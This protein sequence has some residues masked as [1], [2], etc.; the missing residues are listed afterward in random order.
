MHAVRRA[1]LITLLGVACGPVAPEPNATLDW[2]APVAPTPAPA[3]PLPK[4]RVEGTD[5]TDGAR[6]VRLRGVNVCSLEFDSTGANWKLDAAG[7]ALLRTLADPT[8]WKANVVRMP[9]NQ[10]WFLEDDAYV[11]RIE[12]IIDDANRLGLYVL[13]EVQW[14]LGKTLEP[15]HRNILQLPTFGEG[16]TTEAFWLRATSR[17]ANRTNLLYDLINEPHGFSDLDTARAMQA[18]VSA[19]R[20]RDEQTVI[21]V[22]G[23]NW[24]HSVDYYRTHPLEGANLVYSAHQYLPHDPP[25]H[26]EGAFVN[27]ARSLPVLI[28]EFLAEADDAAYAS[29]LVEVAEANALEGWLPWAIGCGFDED[30]DRGGEPLASLARRM[31][32]LN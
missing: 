8:R 26:F 9:V 7:S 13:L 11:E 18:L 32:E 1:L 27:A 10:Q 19:I 16:N 24:A 28:G 4:L 29:E 2:G 20:R 22:A 15:Y 3:M 25:S 30:G 21:V 14:E 23:S 5:L 31:R 12:R 6:T 17:W